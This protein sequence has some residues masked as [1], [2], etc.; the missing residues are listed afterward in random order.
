MESYEVEANRQRNWPISR[1]N[2][3]VNEGETL[4]AGL[5]LQANN[6]AVSCCLCYKLGV[7]LQSLGLEILK[8]SHLYSLLSLFVILRKKIIVSK[9]PHTSGKRFQDL[10]HKETIFKS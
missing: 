6:V 5:S 1:I 7:R 2:F 8:K 4:T 10:N 9:I 3:R